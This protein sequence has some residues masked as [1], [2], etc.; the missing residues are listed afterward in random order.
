MRAVRAMT[1]FAFVLLLAGCG[2]DFDAMKAAEVLRSS[3]KVKDAAQTV[4]LLDGQSTIDAMYAKRYRM[5]LAEQQGWMH[6][7]PLG[8]GKIECRLTTAGREKSKAWRQGTDAESGAPGWLVPVTRFDVSRVVM[9]EM[10]DTTALATFVGH[11]MNNE[12]APIFKT[13]QMREPYDYSAAFSKVG[14]EWMVMDIQ[15]IRR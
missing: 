14:D 4:F 9:A 3:P 15:M 6:C 11:Q 1:V 12:Y 5:E 7:I 13:V 2:D 10:T 8:S